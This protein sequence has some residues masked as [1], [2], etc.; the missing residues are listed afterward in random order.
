MSKYKDDPPKKSVVKNALGKA[1]KKVKEFANSFTDAK[2]QVQQVINRIGTNP[3]LDLKMSGFLFDIYNEKRQDP[4]EEMRMC[5][6]AYRKNSYVVS[7]VELFAQAIL[8]EQITVK[9]NNP[10]LPEEYT[11][12]VEQNVIPKLKNPLKEVIEETIKTGNGYLYLTQPPEK[13]QVPKVTSL[14]R[15]YDVYVDYDKSLTPTRYIYHVPDN[16]Q[17]YESHTISYFNTQKT[18][19]GMELEKDRVIHFKYGKSHIPVYGRS[20]LA[21]SVDDVNIAYNLEKNLSIIARNKGINRKIITINDSEGDYIPEEEMS[22]IQ[23]EYNRLD[24][25]QN[26]L[27]SNYEVDVKDLNYAGTHY[28]PQKDLE[29]LKRKITMMLGPSFYFHGDS[30]NYSVAD[31]Q[32]DMFR[33]SVLNFRDMIKPKLNELIRRCV[34]KQFGV[35]R[36]LHELSID[37]GEYTFTSEENKREGVIKQFRA[38][39]ITLNEAREEL[40]LE[41]DEEIG[42]FY[43]FDLDETKSDKDQGGNNPFLDLAQ[44]K[45]STLEALQK[46]KE[47]LDGE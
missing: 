16:K 25:S 31:D 33:L 28:E 34:R 35:T 42:G 12:Y 38:G 18:I 4:H 5:E 15:S 1:R 2:T 9:N 41:P 13:N 14:S 45:Q 46:Q 11:R 47:N 23:R 29:Y 30:T 44:T 6:V 8:G 40:G 27:L 32:K 10:D 36:S 22:T 43:R 7:G 20:N 17:D 19:R 26:F 21:S 37:F 24:E 3:S 39:L